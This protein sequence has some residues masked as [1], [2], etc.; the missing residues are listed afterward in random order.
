MIRDSAPVEGDTADQE[1]TDA[2]EL[3]KRLSQWHQTMEPKKVKLA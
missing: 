3:E 2:A 1:R